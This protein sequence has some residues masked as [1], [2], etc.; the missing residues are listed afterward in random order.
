LGLSHNFGDEWI[1]LGSLKA[2]VDGSFGSSTALLYEPYLNEPA[3]HGLYA[4][5]MEKLKQYV[6]EAD[7]RNFQV[8]IHAIGDRAVSELL[9]LYLEVSSEN[10]TR[11]RRFRIEHAASV[12][13]EDMHKFTQCNA[14]ASVQPYHAIDD[15][16]VLET[17]IGHE[18]CKYTYPFKS[19]LEHGVTMS[20]GTDWYVAPLN[21]FL[22]I[23]AA[24]NR[25]T[26]D[27]KNPNGWFPEQKI[28]VPEAI[29]AYTLIPAYAEFN[30]TIK[31]TLTPGKLADLVVLS[32][33]I[34]TAPPDSISETNILMTM[35]G[36]NVVYD[37]TGS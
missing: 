11:D 19:F 6:L 8:S 17:R 32:Q 22:T 3:N 13:P 30:E 5:P 31:G 21:P 16:R 4:T 34:I 35:V 33:D 37:Q 28:S 14:I 1:K 7:R 9:D 26:I 23:D 12:R 20:F 27:G 29:R 36:G 15:G 25:A 24:V 10:G 18:R 2:F